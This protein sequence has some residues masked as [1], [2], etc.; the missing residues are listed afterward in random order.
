MIAQLTMMSVLAFIGL[1]KTTKKPVFGQLTLTGEK[2]LDWLKTA[3]AEAKNGITYRVTKIRIA[4]AN[5]LSGEGWNIPEWKEGQTFTALLTLEEGFANPIWVHQRSAVQGIEQ[6]CARWEADG[7]QVNDKTHEIDFGDQPVAL[8]F[9]R[10]NGTYARYA[11][12]QED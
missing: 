11:V 6:M 1:A 8:N 3:D 2:A 10:G 9:K 12:T 4:M 5:T 7:A